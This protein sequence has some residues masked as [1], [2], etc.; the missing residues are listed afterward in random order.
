MGPRNF[1]EWFI[2]E[3]RKST[4][5]ALQ[6]VKAGLGDESLVYRW[7]LGRDEYSIL[8]WRFRRVFAVIGGED[9]GT[10]RM[11]TLARVQQRRIAAALR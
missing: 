2:Q 1:L 9:L 3:L 11:L 8:V 5:L 6:P 10:R 7:K 4:Q